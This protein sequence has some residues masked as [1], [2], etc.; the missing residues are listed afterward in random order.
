MVEEL[1]RWKSLLTNRLN[2]VQEVLKGLMEERNKSRSY[3]IGCL[4]NLVQMNEKL[5][6]DENIPLKSSNILELCMNNFRISENLSEKLLEETEVSNSV[7]YLS[8]LPSST[9]AESLALQ[10]FINLYSKNKK[11]IIFFKSF[12]L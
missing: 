3:A 5:C 8:Q 6:N 1:A 10:V 7:E 11:I 4:N 12:R 9:P 2:N